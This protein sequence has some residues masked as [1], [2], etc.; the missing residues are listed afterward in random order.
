MRFRHRRPKK[1]DRRLPAAPAQVPPVSSINRTGAPQGNSTADPL[2]APRGNSTAA[3][4]ADPQARSTDIT[5]PATKIRRARS[6]AAHPGNSTAARL[7][8]STE[9]PTH[10]RKTAAHPG[11]SM[12]MRKSARPGSKATARAAE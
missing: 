5:R 2:E 7:G 11:T 9:F 8:S 1:I 6:T 4:S 3:P 10:R 12:G